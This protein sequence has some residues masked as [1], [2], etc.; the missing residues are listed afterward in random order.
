MDTDED[1]EDPYCVEVGC[2]ERKFALDMRCLNHSVQRLFRDFLNADDSMYDVWVDGLSGLDPRSW[3]QVR[4]LISRYELW[5]N[6][7]P[8]EHQSQ[9]IVAQVGYAI[10][11][12]IL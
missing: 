8:Y 4:L 11:S 2:C 10:Y 9:I 12:L 6:I 7:L 5:R 1:E 3:R